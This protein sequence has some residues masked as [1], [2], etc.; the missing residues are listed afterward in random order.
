M[1]KKLISKNH[2]TS[3]PT[4][5]SFEVSFKNQQKLGNDFRKV[6]SLI[7]A[8]KVTQ[9]V[10]CLPVTGSLIIIDLC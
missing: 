8:L 7:L 3:D 4:S 2:L 9:E 1:R 6:S 10:L 5:F